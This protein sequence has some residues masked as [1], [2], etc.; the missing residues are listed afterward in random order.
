MKKLYYLIVLALILG[1]V[2]T[3]CTLLSNIGQVPTIE[4]SDIT[5]LTKHTAD[6]PQ[7]IDLLAGQTNK[8]GEVKVWNDADNLYVKYVITDPDWCLTETHLHV[9]ESE[10]DIPQKN[11]NPI[12]GHF[13]Y[14]DEFDL[15]D[16]V[17]EALY[18]IPLDGWHVDQ[19]LAIAAHAVV[20]KL[21]DVMTVTLVSDTQTVS[22]G[23]TETEPADP[24]DPA[25]YSGLGTWSYAVPVSSPPIPPWVDPSVVLPGAVWVSSAAT[26]EGGFG[27]QWRLFKEEF[28]IP[29]GAVNI[30][31]GLLVMTADN[32]VEA[33]FNDTPVG[34]TGNV[35]GTAP[36]PQ[37][38]NF[39][40]LWG[41]YTLTPLV[42]PNTLMFV[43]RNWVHTAYNPTGLIYKLDYE[44]QLL[45]EETAWAAG[46]DFP[47]ANWATYFNYE[48]QPVLVDTVQVYAIDKEPIYSTILLESGVQYQLEAVGTAFAGG[49]YTEDIE[50][51][52]K[53]SITHSKTGD[54]WTDTVTGYESYGTTLLDLFVD[55]SSVDWGAL[56]P[57]HTYYL[58]LTGTSTPVEVELWI[59]D[60]YYPNNTGFI[61][62]NIYRLFQCHV[63]SQ[64][65]ARVV[66]VLSELYLL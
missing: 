39:G 16:E 3:G 34:T 27:D 64:M 23:Y 6:D 1:L 51:D 54:T 22:A 43:V 59:Y 60:I 7:V 49:K 26:T 53:Y 4:Q 37:P 42:G 44:Y 21:S 29:T 65:S 38:Y 20:Q 41:P 18:A 57:E 66:L 32:A 5:Y 52:A 30:S 8:V 33:Y 36:S 12:P 2:L 45:E 13:A 47:G 31:G 56:N 9:A 35:Y 61:T 62:V 46:S 58:T 25:K 24:L 48:L 55:G 63:T 10:E 14:S 40:K 15:A 17:T 50:F 28:D 19:E 11:G